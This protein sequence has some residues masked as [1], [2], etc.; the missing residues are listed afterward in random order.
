MPRPLLS[1]PI[2]D[3]QFSP[4]IHD[5][6]PNYSYTTPSIPK[7]FAISSLHFQ[8]LTQSYAT[9]IHPFL[10]INSSPNTL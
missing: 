2:M 9:Y 1:N 7:L 10:L 8:S 4:F 3:N 6:E 5:L